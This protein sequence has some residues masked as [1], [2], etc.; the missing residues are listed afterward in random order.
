MS[1]SALFY[2]NGCLEGAASIAAY[3]SPDTF[4]EGKEVKGKNRMYAQR[5]ALVLGSFSISSILIANQPDSPAKQIYAIGWF[6]FH[7]GVTLERSLREVKIAS[8]I[9]HGALSMGFLY[10]LYQSGF[11]KETIV[12]KIIW[13]KK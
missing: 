7:F 2:F 4:T 8:V 13:R 3:Y 1:L 12:P 6:L 11:Q 9:I 5:F 10:Y